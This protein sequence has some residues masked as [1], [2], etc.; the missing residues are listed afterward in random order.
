MG[1]A[2]EMARRSRSSC[3]GARSVQMGIA[4]EVDVTC[5]VDHPNPTK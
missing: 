5:S 1:D 3:S 4:H 2:D